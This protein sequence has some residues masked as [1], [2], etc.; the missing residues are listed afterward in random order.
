[1]PC[2]VKELEHCLE[3]IPKN[4]ISEFALYQIIILFFVCVAEIQLLERHF[5]MDYM[6]DIKAQ[7]PELIRRYTVCLIVCQIQLHQLENNVTI[8]LKEQ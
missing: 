1:M 8:N 2:N 4:G 6:S 5:E 7:S 3:T